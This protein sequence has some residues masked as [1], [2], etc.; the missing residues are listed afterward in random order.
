MSPWIGVLRHWSLTASTGPVTAGAALAAYEG[1]FSWPLLLLCLL[2]GWLLQ[3]AANLLNTYGDHR[4]GVDTAHRPPTA[5]QLVNGALRPRSVLRAGLTVLA[6]GA[7]VGLAAVAFSDARL[8]LF[9]AAGVAAA[10]FYTTGLRLKYAGLGLPLVMVAMGILMVMASHFAQARALS[11]A[12]V[13]VSLPV[14]CLVGAVL[15]GNDLRDRVGDRHAGILTSS[16][17]IGP[18]GARWLFVTLHTLPYL[19]LARCVTARQLPLWTLLPLLAFPLSVAVARDCLR[20][21]TRSLEGRSAGIHFV[22]G[23]LLTLGL[24]LAHILRE[25]PAP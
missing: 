1:S 18:R 5:P 25:S 20:G 8:L 9:A 19:L 21:E 10:G 3:V 6:L 23:T 11:P 24:V 17:L 16:L 15:H 4:S 7:A 12:A 13:W 22:F 14:A 2:S